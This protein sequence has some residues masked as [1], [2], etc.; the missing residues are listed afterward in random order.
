MSES[1]FHLKEILLD[2]R[3]QLY[4]NKTV[5]NVDDLSRY[6][7]LSKSK[8]YKL[9]SLDL[10]PTGS[11]KNIRQKFFNKEDIDRWLLGEPD[12]SDELLEEE[13][14]QKLLK[15]KKA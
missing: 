2:I 11:N 10:I 5:F 12:I 3:D 14:N 8:I 4:L 1:V 6:T 9:T 13:F 15:N 7:G